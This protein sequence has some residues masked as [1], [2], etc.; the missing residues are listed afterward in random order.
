MKE[1]KLEEKRRRWKGEDERRVEEEW[2]AERD[3]RMGDGVVFVRS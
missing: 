2:L 1:E 3:M